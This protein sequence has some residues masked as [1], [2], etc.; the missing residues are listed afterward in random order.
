MSSPPHLDEDR[1]RGTRSIAL[2]GWTVT[3]TKRPILSIPEA[4][5]ASDALDL[6]LPEICFG[7]NV[8]SIRH[9]AS[10]FA[11]EWNTLD[12]L[13]AVKKG[14]GWD[15]QPGS[16]AVRVAHADEW[17]RGQV[18]SGSAAQLKVQKPFDWT[19]TTLHRG[20]TY[21]ASP[22]AAPEYA[23]WQSAPPTHPGIPLPLL[24]RMDIPILFFDEIPLFEDELGD[25][26]IADVTVRVRVND[27]S[28]FILSRFSLRIDGVL[29]RYFD[30]RVF[31]RFGTDE[32][33]RE[34]RGREAPYDVVKARLVP[35]SPSRNGFALPAAASPRS[36]FGSAPS[37]TLEPAEDLTPLTDNNRVAGV[38]EELAL[39][40]DMQRELRMGDAEARLE[41][42]KRWEGLGRRLEVLKVPW[43]ASTPVD[44]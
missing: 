10:G 9:E 7:N 20:N 18:A 23:G 40:E 42:A 12:M 1:S 32:I 29:F 5:A 2:N 19:Y 44:P 37:P 25:N 21:R 28:F 13:K 26:G 36:P 4:D 6:A 27:S 31:H 16:G 38:L 3:A 43:A 14:E 8:L 34:V 35:S 22:L 17:S 33:I 39:A 41:D 24:A 11:L 30:V 15:A